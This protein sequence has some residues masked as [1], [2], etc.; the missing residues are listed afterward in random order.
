MSDT[1]NEQLNRALE[2]GTLCQDRILQLAE[3]QMFGTEDVGLCIACGHEQ[4]GCEPDAREY[5]C[6]ECGK[7]AVYGAPELV[8]SMNVI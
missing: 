1:V 3:E 4:D 7:N 5:K 6:E 8:M 2:A